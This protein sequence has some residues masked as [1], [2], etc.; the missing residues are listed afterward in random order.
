[1]DIGVS[2]LWS[3]KTL[4]LGTSHQSNCRFYLKEGA[5]LAEEIDEELF[6]LEPLDIHLELRSKLNAN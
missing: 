6:E 2:K 4:L 3:G 5:C 1:M